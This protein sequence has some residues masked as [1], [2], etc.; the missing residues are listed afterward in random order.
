LQGQTVVSQQRAVRMRIGLEGQDPRTEE[1][2]WLL[3]A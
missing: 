1:K 2:R 3:V